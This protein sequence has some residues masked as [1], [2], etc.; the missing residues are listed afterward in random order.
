MTIHTSVLKFCNDSCFEKHAKNIYLSNNSLYGHNSD[1]SP[2]T[3]RSS[4]SHTSDTP[5]HTLTPPATPQN[6]QPYPIKPKHRSVSPYRFAPHSKQGLTLLCCLRVASPEVPINPPYSPPSHPFYTPISPHSLP[7]FTLLLPQCHPG[8]PL[9]YPSL[10]PVSPQAHPALT[11]TSPQSYPNLTPISP[12]SHPSHGPVT[13]LPHPSCMPQAH[14]G[15]ITLP[16]HLRVARL[17]HFTCPYPDPNHPP[18][19]L[20]KLNPQAH[21]AV[22]FEGGQ[23]PDGVADVLRGEVGQL[24]CSMLTQGLQERPR[25]VVG[26]ACIRPD[27]IGHALRLK[28][29]HERLA[30]PGCCRHHLRV[31]LTCRRKTCME[32]GYPIP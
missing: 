16:C 22:P 10:T 9:P 5:S 29:M 6:C 31:Q 23:S 1:A 11:P 13:S 30:V 14:F 20:H 17:D 2:P 32:E 28:G 8:L 3:P 24:V 4:P 21:L 19:T 27:H 15:A 25:G 12:Q 18:V 7:Q 26:Q